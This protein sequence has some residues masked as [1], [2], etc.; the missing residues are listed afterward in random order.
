MIDEQH[1]ERLNRHAGASGKALD[2]G[3]VHRELRQL[4]TKVGRDHQ[5]VLVPEVLVVAEHPREGTQERRLQVG[6]RLAVGDV[7]DVEALID[8]PEERRDVRG[9]VALARTFDDLGDARTRQRARLALPGAE[10]AVK[11]TDRLVEGVRRDQVSAPHVLRPGDLVLKHELRLLGG[12]LQ[13]QQRGRVGVGHVAQDDVAVE[14]GLTDVQRFEASTLELFVRVEVNDHAQVGHE[15]FVDELFTGGLALESIDDVDVIVENP[16][17]LTVVDLL[18]RGTSAHTQVDVGNP[19]GLEG[20][21]QHFDLGG[22]QNLPLVRVGLDVAQ[23]ERVD[24]AT[25]DDRLTVVGLERIQ[26]CIDDSNHGFL[27]SFHEQAPYQ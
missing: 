18:G 19:T 26:C 6:R 22:G 25:E 27:P 16:E 1:L 17:R 10:V 23:M 5:P 15:A 20:A 11:P 4:A 13:H 21:L 12:H 9:E 3:V 2:R 8:E 24:D 14:P 7:L